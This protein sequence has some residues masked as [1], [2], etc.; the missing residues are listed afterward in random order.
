MRHAIDAEKKGLLF[1][2]S[3]PGW[4]APPEGRADCCIVLGRI[5]IKDSALNLS[6]LDLTT[7]ARS[8]QLC[9]LL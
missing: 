9:V 4:V 6:R 8:A 1:Q 5:A 2:G 7:E 3:G